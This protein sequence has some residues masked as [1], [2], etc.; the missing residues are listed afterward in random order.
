MVISSEVTIQREA[1]LA[2][3]AE[4]RLSEERINESVL[5]ILKIKLQLEL[6]D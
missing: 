5:R 3:V 2:A 1:V 6:I 4:G